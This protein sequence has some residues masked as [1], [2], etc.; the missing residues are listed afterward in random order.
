MQPLVS[1]VVPV[2]NGEKY[3][4]SCLD[5]IIVQS[6]KNLEIIVVD[7]GSIDKTA[8]IA[9]KYPV[10]LVSMDKNR[11]LSAARNRGMDEALGEYIHFLDGDDDVSPDYYK[12][13][14]AAITE[15]GSDVACGGVVNDKK[16]Y[17]TLRF[18]KRKVYTTIEDKFKA[19]YV[20]KWGYVWRYLYKLDFLRE[21]GY[22]FEEGRLI[23]DLAF[24]LPT[25]YYSNQ[26]V[27]V[28]NADYFYRF[29]ENSIMST[30]T[31]AH[32]EKRRKDWLHAKALRQEFA[33]THGFKIYGVHKG[34]FMYLI[35]KFYVSLINWESPF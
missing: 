5:S 29:R 30:K 34:K 9:Q 35:R 23:E 25:V 17:K 21:K 20:G 1:I 7:D 24:S 27:V 19:S 10:K 14:V 12:E 6:Y 3:L 26:L 13:M 15:T 2:Y 33:D 8:E 16:S 11:G 32:A 4:K 22:R 28:P 18:K 31:K